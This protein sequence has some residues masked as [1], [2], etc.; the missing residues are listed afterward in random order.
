LIEIENC[1]K[2]LE[3]NDIYLKIMT[4]NLIVEIW[5]KDLKIN[6]YGTDGIVVSGRIDS[7]E[8]T[9]RSGWRKNV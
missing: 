7:I 4:S 2:I 3:Y 1:K 5:G 6:N 9:K 8:F